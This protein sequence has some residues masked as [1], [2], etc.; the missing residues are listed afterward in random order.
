MGK[1]TMPSW[2]LGGERRISAAEGCRRL[3]LDLQHV[4]N[5]TVRAQVMPET[6]APGRL[7][8]AQAA[9]QVRG[10]GDENGRERWNLVGDTDDQMPR[11]QQGGPR[12]LLPVLLQ[13]TPES[14]ISR[15]AHCVCWRSPIVF[16]EKESIIMWPRETAHIQNLGRSPRAFL[17]HKSVV[18]S[19]R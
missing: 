13:N 17:E 12:G 4:A 10:A 19:V 14:N 2:A 7:H 1:Y 16:S 8:E 5:Q 15:T 18:A 3:A 11:G 6:P 9:P